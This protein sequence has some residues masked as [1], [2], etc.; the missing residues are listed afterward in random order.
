M[1]ISNHIITGAV[2]AVATKNPP[3]AISLSYLSHF[4][5]DALPHFGP[6]NL[7]GLVES[8]KHWTFRLGV[9]VE[10]LTLI[11]VLFLI[12][13]LTSG[14]VPIWLLIT[15]MVVSDLPDLLWIPVY[16]YENKYQKSKKIGRIAKF[17]G[18]IQNHSYWGIVT[19]ITWLT[20]MIFI[21]FRL[22]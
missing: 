8:V 19:E 16:Y 22:T 9:I 15:C 6:P 12:F 13:Y 18:R 10:I 17:H 21:L 14:I 7:K 3:L 11:P 1:T 5:L 4:V 20:L 2:I